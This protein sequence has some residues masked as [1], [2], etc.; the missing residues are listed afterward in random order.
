LAIVRTITMAMRFEV[1]R[2]SRIS[3]LIGTKKGVH[4]NDIVRKRERW[5]RTNMMMREVFG[6]LGAIISWRMCRRWMRRRKTWWIYQF[7]GTIGKR[8]GVRVN[9]ETDADHPPKTLSG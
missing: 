8:A 4:A 1:S 5:M 2:I 7:M 9:D 6:R 3:G